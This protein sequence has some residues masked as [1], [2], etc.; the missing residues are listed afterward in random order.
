MLKTQWLLAICRSQIRWLI[1]GDPSRCDCVHCLSPHDPHV[2]SQ[3]NYSK[4]WTFPPQLV[5]WPTFSWHL[6]LLKSLFVFN[7][8]EVFFRFHHLFYLVTCFSSL[9]PALSCQLLKDNVSFVCVF[10]PPGTLSQVETRFWNHFLNSWLWIFTAGNHL[11]KSSHF[12]N[13]KTK[14]QRG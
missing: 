14:G 2:L 9:Y 11:S 12:I 3:L 5:T 10:S 6:C 8:F 13:E 4:P 1:T 7:S